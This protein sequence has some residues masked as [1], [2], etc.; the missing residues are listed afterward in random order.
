[1]RLSELTT[2]L[3]MMVPTLLVTGVAILTLLGPT[4]PAD[5]AARQAQ[6]R[7]AYVAMACA[8]AERGGYAA[9]RRGAAG[10]S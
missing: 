6:A 2:L 9:A 3:G 1:M 8:G 4:T 5:V 7:P 10:G